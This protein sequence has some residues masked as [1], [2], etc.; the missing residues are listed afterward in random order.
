MSIKKI[1][2]ELIEVY[3]QE[4]FDI[5]KEKFRNHPSNKKN[6]EKFYVTIII[7]DEYFIPEPIEISIYEFLC[8][9]KDDKYDDIFDADQTDNNLEVKGEL[10]NGYPEYRI[11]EGHTFLSSTTLYPSP[12]LNIWRH[13][14]VNEIEECLKLVISLSDKENYFNYILDLVREYKET[15]EKIYKGEHNESILKILQEIQ[16]FLYIKSERIFEIQSIIDECQ[17]KIHFNIT[18]AQLSKLIYLLLNKNI[19]DGGNLSEVT[20]FFE[21]YTTV[22]KGNNK[23]TPKTLSAAFRRLNSGSKQI[24]KWAETVHIIL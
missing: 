4:W 12:S 14:I 18:Q 13:T 1:F 11:K 15:C 6:A 19:L 22:N 5:S 2:D 8:G 17:E 24:N 3:N 21:K 7:E 10:P 16:D 20:N 9:V 23:V